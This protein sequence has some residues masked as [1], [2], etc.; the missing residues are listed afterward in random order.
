M[1]MPSCPAT[2]RLGPGVHGALGETLPPA[3]NGRVME[4]LPKFSRG[5]HP[6][7]AGYGGNAQLVDPASFPST[8][9]VF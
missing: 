4:I 2:P 6:L 5:I 1:S 9:R 8:V 7:T 3:D